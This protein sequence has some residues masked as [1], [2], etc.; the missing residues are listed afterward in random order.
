MSREQSW[1][2]ARWLWLAALVAGVSYFVAALQG[3]QGPAIIAWKTAGVGLLTLWAAANARSGYG[4]LL[5]AVL[6]FGA[7]GDAL[8]E[9]AG[10]LA[11]AAAFAVGH[12]IAIILYMQNRRNNLSHSQQLLAIVLV[13]LVLIISWELTRSAT[14]G[15]V[16]SAVA[17]GGGVAVM[18][19]TAWT[20]RFP[21]YRTG[22]GAMMFL[23]SDMLIFGRAGGA[24]PGALAGWLI[25]PLY[26]GGQALIA[27]GVL[28]T[29]SSEVSARAS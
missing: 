29:L 24:M 1:D 19:S 16:I 5:V 12:L 21:R 22:I 13:P 23:V 9:C 28:K 6:G 20:S 27:W 10:L 15:E 3:W 14:T 17:Y 7:L 18:A 8:I 26:F 4:W 2:R 25:W 11:G